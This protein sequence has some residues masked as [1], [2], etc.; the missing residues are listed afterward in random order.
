MDNY[1]N[2]LDEYIKKNEAK[3][4]Y[5]VALWWGAFFIA[6]ALNF[7]MSF[8][9]NPDLSISSVINALVFAVAVVVTPPLA[10]IVIASIWVTKRNNRTRKKIIMAWL[11][12]SITSQLVFLIRDG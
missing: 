5:K 9:L 11:I 7:S 3:K 2:R 4:Q 10:H 6:I 8:D 12:F 1:E